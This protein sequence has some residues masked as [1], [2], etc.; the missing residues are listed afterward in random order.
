MK[1]YLELGKDGHLTLPPSIC[2]AAK[3]QEGDLLK[4]VI[5]E[6]GS[7]HLTAVTTEE[8][9]LVEQSQLKDIHSE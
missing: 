9:K 4:P 8:R 6:D 3:I 5:E 7:I 1:E 2:R